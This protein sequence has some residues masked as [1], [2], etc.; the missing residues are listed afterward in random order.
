MTEYDDDRGLREI[1]D[2]FYS[3]LAELNHDKGLIEDEIRFIENQES[4]LKER[5]LYLKEMLIEVEKNVKN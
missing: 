2:A 4:K 1:D 3:K 5:L